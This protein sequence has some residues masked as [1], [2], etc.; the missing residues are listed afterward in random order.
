MMSQQVVGSSNLGK[1]SNNQN[2]ANSQIFSH[3]QLGIFKQ[4]GPVRATAFDYKM[5]QFGGVQA[6]NQMMGSRKHMSG[7]NHGSQKIYKRSGMASSSQ[8][9]LRPGTA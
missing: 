5:D 7:A 4:G 2:F 1:A 9:G 3:N 8:G 6:T